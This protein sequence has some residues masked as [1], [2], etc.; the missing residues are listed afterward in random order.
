M[1]RLD[2]RAARPAMSYIVHR[3]AWR[4]PNE[5]VF[6]YHESMDANP[7]LPPTTSAG[8]VAGNGVQVVS[9]LTRA[10]ADV[11]AGSSDRELVD[12]IGALEDVKNACSAGQARAAVALQDL[13]EDAASTPR[14]REDAHRSVISEVALARRESPHRA[15]T[16]LGLATAL[17]TELPHTLAALE[18]GRISEWRAILIARETA[19]LDPDD[20]REVDREL[21]A[22]VDGWSNREVA[23]RARQAAYA[24]DPRSVVAHAARAEADRRVTIRPAPACMTI[25]SALLPVAQGVAVHATLT[26][27][28]DAARAAGDERGRGQ[29]MAD[30][31]VTRITG[32]SHPGSV[33]VEVQVVITDDALLGESDTAARLAGHGPIPAGLA[34][35]LITHQD[36]GSA[37]GDAV[38][39]WVRR[40]YSDPQGRL[41]AMESTRRLFPAGLSRFITTRD[42]D[43]CRTPWCGAPISHIDHVTPHHAG[44]PT[45]ASNGQGLCAHCNQTK[46]APGWDARATPDA[47]ITLTTPT[48][49]TY[50]TGPPPVPHE[51][52]SRPA[53]QVRHGL[54][55]KDHGAPAA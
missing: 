32:Q 43:T 22:G 38:S 1:R 52:L 24:L 17:T 55:P 14:H 33:P 54:A 42:A 10:V 49:H 11:L 46:E 41:V 19:C 3:G 36:M 7:G 45:T 34:R 51:P 12:L 8:Q 5:H 25:V 23:A 30:T 39:R 16:L 21:S 13:R 9:A 47:T 31:L 50:S 37:A 20:R 48:G 2:A 18:D 35:R 29:V 40:L 26:R 15:R 4:A 6:D 27:E 28:A 44:G 53:P